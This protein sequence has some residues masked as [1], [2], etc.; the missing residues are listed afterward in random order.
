MPSGGA[1]LLTEPSGD[2]SCE[3]TQA[4]SHL[5]QAVFMTRRLSSQ[6]TAPDPDAAILP[7]GGNARSVVI[8]RLSQTQC[9]GQ[10]AGMPARRDTLL[11]IVIAIVHRFNGHPLQL[12]ETICTFSL[13]TSK[14]YGQKKS[15]TRNFWGNCAPLRESG[16]AQEA[17]EEFK[18]LG[19]TRIV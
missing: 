10:I 19:W 4:R 16:L 15:A 11:A 3:N 14:S 5:P 8:T 12:S 17:I 6:R 9:R 1:D 18:T 7:N 2:R 13:A